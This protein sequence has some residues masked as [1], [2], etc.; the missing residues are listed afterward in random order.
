MKTIKMSVKLFLA[1]AI[2]LLASC[3]EEK[4]PSNG[5][6]GELPNIVTEMGKSESELAK[7][8][9]TSDGSNASELLE[10]Y[11]ALQKVADEKIKVAK[12]SIVGKKIKTEVDK[13]VL[14]KVISPMKIDDVKSGGKIRLSCQCELEND[15]SYISGMG[16]VVPFQEMGAVLKDTEGK[17]IYAN[18]MTVNLLEGKSKNGIY[19]KGTKIETYLTIEMGP[20]NAADMASLGSILITYRGRNIYVNTDKS[21]KAA[22]DSINKVKIKL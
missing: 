19:P 17:E 22:K 1:G 6:L 2:A 4:L 20:W 3:G 14:L 16:V 12:T 18:I 21:S 7:K 11:I 10:S 5:P 9:Q 8:V 13:G 15:G